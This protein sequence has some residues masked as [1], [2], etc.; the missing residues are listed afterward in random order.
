MLLSLQLFLLLLLILIH[1]KSYTFDSY[2]YE[3]KF[4]QCSRRLQSKG[5]SEL[6]PNKLI[7]ILAEKEAG[8]RCRD[9]D[10]GSESLW[11]RCYVDREFRS[12]LGEAA[13]S[14]VLIFWNVVLGKLQDRQPS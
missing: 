14:T 11:R 7:G 4:L 13:T 8:F 9:S 12:L 3:R 5:H 10:V 2:V 1:T 6:P